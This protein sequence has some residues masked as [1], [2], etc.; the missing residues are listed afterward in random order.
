LI[1]A[2]ALGAGWVDGGALTEDVLEL[3]QAASAARR[4]RPNAGAEMIRRASRWDRVT[5]L[6]TLGQMC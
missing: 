2:V 5:R 6:L 4:A 3:P 1:K